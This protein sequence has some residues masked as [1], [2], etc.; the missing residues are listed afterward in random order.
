MNKSGRN[1]PDLASCSHQHDIHSASSSDEML[2]DWV[3]PGAEII[4]LLGTV[5]PMA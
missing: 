3:R 4:K 2:A 5:S 1:I